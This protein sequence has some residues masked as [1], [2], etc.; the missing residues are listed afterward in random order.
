[1]FARSQG[2]KFSRVLSPTL[3]RSFHGSSQ[4]NHKVTVVGAAGGIGQPLS[5]LAKLSNRVTDLRLYDV[6]P[7]T[8]GVAAD[9]SHC[10]TAGK[11]SG[12][13]GDQLGDALSGTDVVIIPAGVP[14]KPGM[15]RDDLFNINA[16]IVAGIAEKA[17][18]ACPNAI[19]LIIS[20]PVNSTVPI[21]AEVMKK[22]NRYD[23]RKVVGVTMLDVCRANT[24]VSENQGFDVNETHVKVIGGHAGKT[25]LPLLSQVS[26]A[27]FSQDDKD[28]LTHRVMFGGDEVVEAKA[29]AGSATL[30]M[31]FAGWKF[32]EQVLKGLSGEKGIIECAYVESDVGPTSFFASPVELGK[33]GVEKI[34]HWG[35][36]DAFEQEKL[37]DMVGDLKNQIAK[38][39]DFAKQ[40]VPK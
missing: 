36:V 12:Y 8:P 2:L 7:V 39:E 9:I 21:F 29:G 40:F 11:V 23:K 30:S 4:R 15:T 32:A 35:K 27:K 5:L 20:N 34:H 16:G 3:L 31:A 24:F 1:M 38:G 18:T 17:A 19:F 22:H 14:R 6:A 13:V 10:N 28:K 25:I 26:N 37:D 33:S